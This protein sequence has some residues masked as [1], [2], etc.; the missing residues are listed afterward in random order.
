VDDAFGRKENKME[1]YHNQ[2]TRLQGAA[3]FR[4]HHRSFGL[5]FIAANIHAD[6]TI[7]TRLPRALHPRDSQRL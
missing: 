3:S 7:L 6:T 2:V 4:F 1:L 5:Y